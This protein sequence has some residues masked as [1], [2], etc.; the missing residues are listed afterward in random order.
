MEAYGWGALSGW[1]RHRST[2]IHSWYNILFLLQISPENNGLLI[3]NRET[4][5]IFASKTK[6]NHGWWT[7]NRSPFFKAFRFDPSISCSK[8]RRKTS[9]I[10]SRFREIFHRPACNGITIPRGFAFLEWRC[11]AL[12][13]CRTTTEPN[14]MIGQRIEGTGSSSHF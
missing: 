1:S 10:N 8:A 9:P 5:G 2:P 7:K 11:G 3:P 12:P 14:L 6:Q 13:A 4:R